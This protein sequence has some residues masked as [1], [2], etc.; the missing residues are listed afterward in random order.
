MSE[1]QCYL[2]REHILVREHI[3]RDVCWSELQCYLPRHMYMHMHMHM[4]MYMYMYMHMHMHMHI[5]MYMHHD[6]CMRGIT[7]VI[8]T[9]LGV[10]MYVLVCKV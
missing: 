9:R 5:Y 4:H 2:A 1:L 3:L 7:A 8:S 6:I 10:D